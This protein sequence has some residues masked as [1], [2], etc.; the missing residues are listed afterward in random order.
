MC[1]DH[2][3]KLLNMQRSSI[4]IGAKVL[5]LQLGIKNETAK[6]LVEVK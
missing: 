5:W 2:Q 1:L 4:K 6:K 3:L